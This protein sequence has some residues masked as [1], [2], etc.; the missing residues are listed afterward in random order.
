VVVGVLI[1]Q[2]QEG[3]FL[4]HGYK[5]RAELITRSYDWLR[6]LW[7]FY[8]LALGSR[9]VLNG[10]LLYWISVKRKER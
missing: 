8:E 4:N 9:K 1:I 5:A 7:W 6:G 2:P 3:L 10:R